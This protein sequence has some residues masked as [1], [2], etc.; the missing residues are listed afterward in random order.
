[1]CGINGIVCKASGEDRRA[2]EE[3][4][5]KMNRLLAHRGPDGEGLYSDDTIT[6]GHR[7]LAIIDLSEHGAQ[8]MASADGS[9]VLVFNGEI[10]NYLELREELE[11]LGHAFK[12]QTDTE[13][14]LSAYLQWG[15]SCVQRFNGMWAFA[16]WDKRRKRLL[17]SRDRFGVK[18]LYYFEDE[19]S[20]VFSSEI[21]AIA[22]VRGI[23][24]ANLDKVHDYLAYGYR[25]NDGNTFFDDVSELKP[26]HNL[27]WHDGKIEISRYWKL[28]EGQTERTH[29]EDEWTAHF[30]YLLEDAV[31]LRFRSDVP[32][33]LLQSGGL[34]SSAIACIVNDSIEAGGLGCES[35]TAF[36]AAFPGFKMD[37]SYRVRA[38]I[39]TCPKINLRVLHLSGNDLA[40]HIGNFVYDADEPVQSPTGFAHWSVL[41]AIHET[42]CKVTINGQ[43][44]D[45]AWAGYGRN[46][47]G[48]QLL[49]QLLR[50][51]LAF[52]RQFS[53]AKSI[54]PVSQ[55]GLLAQVAKAALGRRAASYMRSKYLEDV[56]D[57][58]TPLFHTEHSS[59]LPGQR[60]RLRPRNMDAHLR[61][62]IENYGFTQILHYEDHSSMAHSVEMRSPFIDYRL[63]ELAFRM[64]DSMKLDMGVTKRVLRKA[65][66]HRLPSEIVASHR[67]IAFNTPV[68]EWLKSSGMKHVITDLLGSAE[69]KN[70]PIWNA[71]VVTRHFETGNLAKFPI[72]R[73]I[74]LELW[75]RAYKISNL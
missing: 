56:W 51:P 45:E 22:S 25:N 19:K 40:Q 67:K 13:V 44:A 69:F 23:R 58:L 2:V 6:L 46:V 43:G 70:R 14:L 41:K 28:P 66:E 1:M 21:K 8:P 61:A 62:Q 20:L 72:W 12:S 35:V 64:P 73:F 38:L 17:L 75:A 47:I 9:V 63:M 42:G 5:R 48:Y 57:A 31:R 24:R 7:R 50:S 3:A 68:D 74:N 36:H 26:A 16:L 55:T 33:A 29:S 39:S 54:M 34:D 53:A 32:V 27:V 30:K 10:Y 37:E 15:D 71:A 65:F 59:Y 11:A 49:D 60:A 4:V 18:P 52:V